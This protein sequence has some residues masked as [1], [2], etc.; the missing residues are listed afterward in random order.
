[1][2]HITLPEMLHQQRAAIG[3]LRREQQAHVVGHETIGVHR[4]F[5]LAGQF[6]QMSEIEPV[7]AV[8]KEAGAAVVP[9]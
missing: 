9:R 3:S 2:L 7:V 8:G 6:V 5:E 4:A 1:M